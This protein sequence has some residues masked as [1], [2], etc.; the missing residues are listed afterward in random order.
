MNP[1]LKKNMPLHSLTTF[2]VVF[3]LTY[4]LLCTE[5]PEIFVMC[6]LHQIV[7]IGIIPTGLHRTA[8]LASASLTGGGFRSRLL[9]GT[10]PGLMSPYEFSMYTLH[11]VTAL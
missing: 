9:E 6:D 5:W 3:L 10:S 2:S 11:F 4:K 1:I 8:F 7:G